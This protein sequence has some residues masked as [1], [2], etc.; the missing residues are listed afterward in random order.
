MSPLKL[1]LIVADERE[2][3]GRYELPE[4]YFGTAYSALLEGLKERQDIEVHIVTC[5]RRQV[6]APERLAGN[7]FYHALQVSRWSF[8]RTA[9]IPTVLKTR[10][11]LRGLRPDLVH[12]QGTERYNALAAAYS[13]FPN[14]ITIHGNMRQIARA[15]AAKPFSFHWV[16]ARLEPYAIRRAGG[17][18]CLSRYTQQQVQA[19]AKKTWLLPNAVEQ[20]YFELAREP[21]E[22]PT[23]LCSANIAPHKNQNQLMRTLDPIAASRRIRLIFLGRLAEGDPYSAEFL[24]LL[25]ARPWCSHAGFLAGEALR[26]HFRTAHMLVLPTL[27]D[28]CPMVV[29]EAMAAGLPVAASR[30]GGIPDLI[31]DGQHGLLFN[32]RDPESVR[33][34]LCKLLAEPQA[35]KA[36]AAQAKSR[37]RERY[38][39]SVIAQRHMEIYREVLLPPQ[40][41]KPSDDTLG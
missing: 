9:Y 29:L 35:A 38:H 4:P 27:E 7:V 34:A 1:A 6:R 39:P 41:R 24:E 13:G 25:K 37:A 16:A 5:V 19:L 33:T 17:V 30:I 11:A 2:A 3:L 15:L 40:G 28:N 36:M 10:K 26:A 21:S 14:V 8:L 22:Q 31:D 32:P 20:A 12:G 18:V 23:L